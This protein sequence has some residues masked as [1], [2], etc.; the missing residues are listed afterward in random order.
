VVTLE[1]YS[2][3]PGSRTFDGPD[4]GYPRVAITTRGLPNDAMTP[5]G[6]AQAIWDYLNATE[7]IILGG[8]LYHSLWPLQSG[9]VPLGR[10]ARN[11]FQFR[12]NIEARR[13]VS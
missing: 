3:L 6:V 11:S 9:V 7:N 1:D 4:I 8:M 13:N 12:I 10:D 2:G 5:R